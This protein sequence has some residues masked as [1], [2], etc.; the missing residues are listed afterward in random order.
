MVIQS[1]PHG[2]PMPPRPTGLLVLA[3][4]AGLWAVG[5]GATGFL[6]AAVVVG[7]IAVV[8]AAL[9]VVKRKQADRLGSPP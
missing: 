2:L 8:C 7:A 6:I 5:L 4:V 1:N 9:G 3:V